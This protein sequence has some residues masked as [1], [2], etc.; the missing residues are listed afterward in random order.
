VSLRHSCAALAG[1]VTLLGLAPASGLRDTLTLD[2][3]SSLPQLR[4]EGANDVE[5][6]YVRRA[7]SRVLATRVGARARERLLSGELPEPLTLVLNHGGD[8]LTRYRV[9]GREL[10]ETIVFDPAAFPLVETEAGI[11]P[12]PPETVLAHELGHAVFKLASEEQVIREVENPVR[13][14]LGLPLRAHF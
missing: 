10:S 8:N 4:I 14:E 5:S 9:A 1:V 11:R 3:S 7:L 6:A 12:A 13:A 2:A